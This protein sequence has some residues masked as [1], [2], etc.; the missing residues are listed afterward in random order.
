[1]GN[2]KS[3]GDVKILPALPAE[4]MHQILTVRTTI[5]GCMCIRVDT[6]YLL[7]SG[8]RWVDWN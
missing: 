1:M 3:F 6:W 7:R 5:I 2:F 4:E 8:G